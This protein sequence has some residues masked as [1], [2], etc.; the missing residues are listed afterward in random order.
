MLDSP[1]Q[2]IYDEDENA[3]DEDENGYDED[4]ND[5]DEDK[6]RHESH[7]EDENP[8]KHTVGIIRM[9]MAMMNL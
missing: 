5:Y 7:G 8:Y 9:V 2:N 6:D 4:E 1:H 3:N